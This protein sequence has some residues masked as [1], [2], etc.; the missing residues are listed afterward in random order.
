MSIQG[1]LQKG[2]SDCGYLEKAADALLT[3]PRFLWLGREVTL[4]TSTSQKNSYSIYSTGDT[5]QRKIQGVAQVEQRGQ[6]L[7]LGKDRNPSWWASKTY[8]GCLAALVLYPLAIPFLAAGLACK[9]IS[10][11]TNPKAKEYHEIVE[12]FVKDAALIEEEQSLKAGIKRYQSYI[13]TH[14]PATPPDDQ[15]ESVK[16]LQNKITISSMRLKIIEDQEKIDTIQPS[17]QN[18]EKQIKEIFEKFQTT[19]YPKNTQ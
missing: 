17:L 8:L 2:T 5:T 9:K 13:Q 19:Y 6:V 12:V 15:N 14:L 3:L 1:L 18:M 10:L 4:Q 16:G 7:N 11:L